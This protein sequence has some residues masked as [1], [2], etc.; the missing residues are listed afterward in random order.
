MKLRQLLRAV[1]DIARDCN[2]AGERMWLLN[3]PWEED[4]LHWVGEGEN[5]RLHGRVPPPAD[6]RRYSVTR[7]GWCRGFIADGD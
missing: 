3:H 6:G 4:L 7:G 5:R 2:E 1:A